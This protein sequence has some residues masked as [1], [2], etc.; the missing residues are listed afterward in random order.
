MP[1]KTRTT[2]TTKR[3]PSTPRARDPK[4]G[5]ARVAKVGK[6]SFRMEHAVVSMAQDIVVAE[7]DS[8][9]VFVQYEGV[10]SLPLPASMREAMAKIEGRSL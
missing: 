5:R 6:S 1:A 10:K 3:T 7:A 9:L 8:T 2:K 4:A